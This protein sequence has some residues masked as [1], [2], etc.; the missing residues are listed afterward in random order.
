MW[1]HQHGANATNAPLDWQDVP[2]E[3]KA[4]LAK[5]ASDLISTMRR[6]TLGMRV[7]GRA[8]KGDE[9]EVWRAMIDAAARGT[10]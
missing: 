7:A 6:P 3:R 10:D 9:A 2:D 8:V 1:L 5:V 4:E